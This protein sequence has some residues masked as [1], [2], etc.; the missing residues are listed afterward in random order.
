MRTPLVV[1]NWKMNGSQNL[2]ETFSE[3]LRDVPDID[4]WLAP[5]FIYIPALTEAERLQGFTQIG[6]QNVHE[7]VQ[8]AFTGEVSAAMVAEMGAK[9]AI[10]GHSERRNIYLE[11][12]TIVDR[13]LKSCVDANLIPLFCVG[14][15]IEERQNGSAEAVVQ[16][17]LR[18]LKGLLETLPAERLVVAYEPIWAIGTGISASPGDADEMHGKIRSYLGDEVAELRILYGGS[19]SP[20][21]AEKLIN[22]SNIDGFLVGG[23][24]LDVSA[25]N[26]ICQLV[27][28]D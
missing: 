15:S 10:I 5:P 24:A 16:R 6:V 21:N 8:G 12:D 14:E 7:E 25:F 27:G 2:C 4:I 1:A 26:E 19:V 22:Q 28:G 18:S 3:Q 20:N 17:Q 9:F 11:N 23:A 13:K